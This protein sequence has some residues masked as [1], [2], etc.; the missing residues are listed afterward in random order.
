MLKHIGEHKRL[1]VVFSFVILLSLIPVA[2]LFKSGYFLSDDGEWMVIRFS[3][4]YQTLRDGQIP[5]RFFGRLNH[6]FGYPIGVFLYPAFMYLATPFKVIGFS[7]ADSIKIVLIL[8][9]LFS[10]FGSF[11]WLRTRFSLLAAFIGSLVYVYFPY[12]I[13][14][15]YVRGSVGELVAFAV[16]PFL[17]YA[18]EKKQIIIGS[19]LYALLILSHNTFA[20]L[21]TP[22]LLLYTYFLNKKSL[23]RIY[24]FGILLS[25]FFW[26]PSITELPLTRF[27]QTAVSD[28]REYF[29]SFKTMPLLSLVGAAI[30]VIALFVLSQRKRKEAIFFAVA[31]LLSVLLASSVSEIAWQFGILPKL[32]QFPWRLLIVSVWTG[33]FLVAYFLQF[34]SG[35]M[36]KW[37]AVVI[38]LI[39]FFSAFPLIQEYKQV[40]RDDGFYATNEDTTTV[41]HEYMPIWVKKIPDKHPEQLITIS[42]G[43]GEISEI[44]QN[45]YKTQFM[46]RS[47]DSASIVIQK[48]YYPG[49]VAEINGQRKEF[50]PSREGYLLL[51]LPAGESRVTASFVETPLRQFADIL[52]FG[53]AITLG[54]FFIFRHSKIAQQVRKWYNKY[55]WRKP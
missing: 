12:H 23:F 45:S 26:L 1:L 49:W 42:K 43:G 20:F 27:S 4:F 14:D 19:F 51:S 13:Y 15:L 10:G 54:I 24:F 46:F 35:R 48:I 38:M 17:M 31:F 44:Y 9:F 40:I 41:R 37:A 18:L 33:S 53:T 28:W 6:G 36:Q 29:L 34:L 3:A 55:L 21:L 16:L 22:F 39:A 5:P 50:A 47:S 25:A 30:T 2:Y 7:F 32:V 8:S 11:L 52:S